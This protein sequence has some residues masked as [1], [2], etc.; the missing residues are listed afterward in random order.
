MMITQHIKLFKPTDQMNRINKIGVV[1]S[2]KK[3]GQLCS[4]FTF[5][6]NY[7]VYEIVK[8]RP[9]TIDENS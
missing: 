2:F 6:T 3:R 9:P 8:S 1:S 4:L 5:N 7:I